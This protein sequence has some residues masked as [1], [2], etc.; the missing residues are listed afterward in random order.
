MIQAA[1][2][3]VVHSRAVLYRSSVYYYSEVVYIMIDN[4]ID[5]IEILLLGGLRAA[6]SP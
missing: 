1:L 5:S 3:C 4:R 2:I 6:L